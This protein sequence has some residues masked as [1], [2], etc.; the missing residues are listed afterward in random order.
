M[1]LLYHYGFPE[2]FESRQQQEG[3]IFLDGALVKF[4]FCSIC[5]SFKLDS[6]Y[7]FPCF[8]PRAARGTIDNMSDYG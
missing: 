1:L 6:S 3:L 5:Q 4:S 7:I 2:C 8:R